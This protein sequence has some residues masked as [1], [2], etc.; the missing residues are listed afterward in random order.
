MRVDQADLRRDG[1]V[2][3]SYRLVNAA[4]AAREKGYRKLDAYSPF[5][6][7][8]LSDALHLHKNKLPLIV[9]LGGISGGT[10]GYL[11]QYYVTVIYFPHQ[12]RRP[13][14]AQLA[15]LHH[16]YL[17]DDDS[18]RS[19]TAVLGMLGLCGLPMPY[20]PV[21]NVPRFARPP[22]TAFSCAS[23]PPIRCSTTTRRA[24]FWRRWSHERYPKLR[25]RM[26]I[27]G[28]LGQRLSPPAA[29][30]VFGVPAGHARSAEIHSAAA[31]RFFRDGRSARPLLGRHGARGHLND[32]ASFIPAK[33]PTASRSTIS[34]PCD[35]EVIQ[36]GEQRYNIYCT[37]CHDRTG[38]GNGMIVRRGYRKPP[39]YHSDRLRQVPN[40]YIF[41]VITNG[42]GAMPDYAAQIQ[43][44][45]R[46]A[47][48]AY[49]RALQLGQQASVNDVPAPADARPREVPNDGQRGGF[50]HH[51]G[52]ADDLKQ[53]R[54]RALIAGVWV[55][56]TAVGLSSRTQPVLSFVSLVVIFVVGL[57]WVSG[58]AD[59]AVPHR[60]RLGR[61]D[62]PACEA[63]TRTLPLVLADVR[64]N[65]DRDQQSLSRG[66]TPQLVAA[67]PML[68]HK[69]PYL[70]MPFFLIRAAV[71]FAGWMFLSWYFN[72][73][74]LKE[75]REGHDAVH[76][77]MSFAGRPRPAILGLQRHV[78]G[79]GLDSV[80]R[81]EVVLHHLR[82]AVHGQPGR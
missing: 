82:H 61:G 3:Q 73:W 57:S 4:R 49:I 47:I 6:I 18:R 81:S 10:L 78:H 51:A 12:H 71:Y 45:D 54:T 32:D 26:L 70:N 46:W 33:A 11:L 43:P 15:R 30:A 72:R 40:G 65:R 79:D 48:V 63:A 14:A 34:V 13:A 50:Q 19:L 58:L 27:G 62:P 22:A 20:H 31:Q 76:G 17:R 24:N 16:H 53:W 29:A 38:N 28:D 42:F 68:K 35:K 23:S 36:Q 77:K 25:L 41:D 56:L 52:V 67:D 80:A 8:E 66:R 69:Q 39:S 7:E 44:H 37:P 64:A 21:F 5:P 2:R 59:A 55:V 1:R 75:D 9:L 74:S 60:R